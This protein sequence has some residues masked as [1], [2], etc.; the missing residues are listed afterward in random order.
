MRAKHP[1]GVG[2]PVFVQFRKGGVAFKHCHGETRFVPIANTDKLLVRWPI[3]VARIKYSVCTT[4]SRERKRK[5]LFAPRTII[6]IPERAA[7][8]GKLPHQQTH[9]GLLPRPALAAVRRSDV[10]CSA[11]LA[12][13]GRCMV[14]CSATKRSSASCEGRKDGYSFPANSVHGFL[15]CGSETLAADPYSCHR[16]IDWGQYA[17]LKFVT[18]SQRLG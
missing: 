9:G 11:G 12:V 8:N 10:A 5:P 18:G 17:R 3:I 4:L 7:K 16:S 2:G 15:Y 1:P 13:R 6:R 14:S